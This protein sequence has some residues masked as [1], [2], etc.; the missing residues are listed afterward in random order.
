MFEKPHPLATRAKEKLEKVKGFRDKASDDMVFLRS[1]MERPVK[2]GAIAP[3]GPQL[4]AKMA[5]YVDNPL[6]ARVL[7]LGPGTGVVTAA[8]LARGVRPQNLLAVE[9]SEEFCRTVA[10]R[11]PTIN[12]E[13]GDAYAL[14]E[15]LA[16]PGLGAF[17][18]HDLDAVVSSLPLM[19]RPEGER[20]KLVLDALAHLKPG[21]PFI[22]FSYALVPPVKPDVSRY[23]LTSSEWIWKNFPPAR[24]WV[25][26]KNQ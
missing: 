14:D 13:R 7:E 3:S 12:L 21:A 20:K 15:L 11:F 4:V 10:R 2:T 9:Y 19:T 5:S 22:Q 16:R 26:R 17:G 24:V 25:Y 18:R 6:T 1:W 23:S 8:L